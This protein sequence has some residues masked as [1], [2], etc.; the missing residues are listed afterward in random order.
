MRL[1]VMIWIEKLKDA[2][3]IPAMTEALCHDPDSYVRFGAIRVLAAVKTKEAIIGLV[4]GLGCDYSNL[5]GFKVTRD[6]NYD[7]EYRDK[8]VTNLIEITGKDFGTDKK[9]WLGWLDQQKTL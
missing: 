2:R 8:I 9:K 1:E 3:S 4:N 7:H 6:H 5:K